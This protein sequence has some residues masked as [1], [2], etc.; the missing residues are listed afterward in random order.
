MSRSASVFS[1][2]SLAA[3]VA[4]V[5]HREL[6]FTVTRGGKFAGILSALDVEIRPVRFF[7]IPRSPTPYCPRDRKK[8]SS[9]SFAVVFQPHS[10]SCFRFLLSLSIYL[11]LSR[12]VCLF[13][14]IPTILASTYSTLISLCIDRRIS[15]VPS[16]SSACVLCG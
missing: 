8:R 2:S 13:P 7:F 9:V 11:C 16:N 5:Q 3:C 4:Y 6:R 10:L 14:S 15:T 12:P 1:L